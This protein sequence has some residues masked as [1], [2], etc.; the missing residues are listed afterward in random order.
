MRYGLNLL[1]W[2]DALTDEALPLLDE[3]KEIGYDAVELPVFELDVD[4][5]AKWGKRLD[6]AGLAR[7]TVTVR[8]VEDNPMSCDPRIRRK[9]VAANKATLDCSRRSAARPSSG[10]TIPPWVISAAP[11]RR[12]TNGTGPSKA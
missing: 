5:Y 12:R 7:T 2:T 1:L 6:E 4:K 8:G 10:R 9:G 3:I 11:D